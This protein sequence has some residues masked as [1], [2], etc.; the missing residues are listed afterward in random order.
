MNALYYLAYCVG[1]IVGPQLFRSSDAPIYS[2]GYEGLLACLVIAI[3]TILVYGLVCHVDNRK[4]DGEQR[5]SQEDSTVDE[6]KAFSDLT[7]MEKR[8]FR[9]TF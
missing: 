1:N 5:L 9:Y 6:T 7:D 4:R 8:N 2:H 3:V